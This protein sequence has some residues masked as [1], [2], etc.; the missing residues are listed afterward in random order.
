VTLDRTCPWTEKGKAGESP[1]VT[2]DNRT[3]VFFAIYNKTSTSVRGG[4]GV[5]AAEE[6][7][8]SMSRNG[9]I[10]VL[11]LVDLSLEILV[12]AFS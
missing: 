12:S 2:T 4:Q 3:S 6:A 11:K 7:Y 1:K 5:Q 9:I 10:C 8:D